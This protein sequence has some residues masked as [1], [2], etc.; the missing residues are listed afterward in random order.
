MSFVNGVPQ[1]FAFTPGVPGVASVKAVRV[2]NGCPFTAYIRFGSSE[3]T[4]AL[5]SG[6]VNVWSYEFA[7]GP[8]NVSFPDQSQGPQ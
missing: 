3:S 2:S 1:S 4:F 5:T 6:Q 8:L 7:Q